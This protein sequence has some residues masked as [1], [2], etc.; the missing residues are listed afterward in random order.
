MFSLHDPLATSV[1][2]ELSE[3]DD[4]IAALLSR[5][6]FVSRAEATTFLNPSYDE[7]LHDPLLMKNMPRAAKRLASAIENKEHIAVWSDYDSD[8]IPGGVLMHDFLKKAGADFENYIPHR[9][10]EGYGVNVDGIEKLAKRGTKLVITID[11]GI[12][13]VVPI[14]RAKELGMDV[15]LTDHHLPGLE[16]PDAFAVIDPKQEGETY[17]FLELCGAALSWK[18]LCAVLA[19]SP[20]IRERVPV[21]W[22]KWLL[23][24]AGLATI[25][26]MVPLVG[27]NRVIARYGLL[28]LRKSPRPGL[29]KLCRGMRVNQRTLTEDDVAFMIA[30]RVNAASRM[31]DPMDAF[32]LFT[33]QDEGEADL[34]AKKLEKANRGRRAAAAAITR[35]VHERLKERTEIPSVIALGNP[36]WRPALLGLVASGIAEEY[37]RPVF[38]WGREGNTA[39]K[40]SCRSD[41]SVHMIEL[42][43][44]AEETFSQFGGHAASGGFTVRDEAIFFLEERLVEAREKAP[45][46]VLAESLKADALLTPEEATLEFLKQLERLAPFGEGNP[47]P[48]FLMRDVFIETIEWFGKGEEHLRLFLKNRKEPLEAISFYAKRELG[49]KTKTLVPQKEQTLLVHLE[50]NTFL[51]YPTARLRLVAIG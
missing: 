42:M 45:A 51:R 28:V 25:A 9:H 37:A 13:D 2:S 6:G 41:G 4:L 29:Q 39:L 26:D 10:E 14:K 43:G 19:V 18:L 16:L 24:M 22:E 48:V 8:G 44:R 47:K 11:S 38:F 33:T 40:G 5:R 50:R 46:S 32:R 49:S 35:E 7:H 27:E 31:G 36:S 15:I 3:Y 1:R 21:G 23:D 17:P 20:A 12:T 34:L 30:P